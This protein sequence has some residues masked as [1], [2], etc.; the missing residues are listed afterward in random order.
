V[1]E[2]VWWFVA[3]FA[4]LAAELLTGT[5][6]LL[7]IAVALAAAGLAAL[8]G[9]PFVLQLL[10]AA[11]VGFG[12][13]LALRRSRFGRARHDPA[14]PL[15]NMD[16]GQ[17]VTVENWTTARTARASYRGALWDLELAPGETAEPGEYVIRA[18]HANRLVVARRRP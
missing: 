3:A 10:V 13:A 7:M 14:E 2:W 15:Q 8:A 11:A 6:Y 18:I 17:S 1:S 4:L 12:G 5:F 16:V 9:A